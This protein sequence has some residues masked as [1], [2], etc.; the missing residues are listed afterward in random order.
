VIRV[1]DQ[2]HWL[3]AVT[4]RL[5]AELRSATSVDVET[6]ETLHSRL[7]QTPTTERAV[8]FQRELREKQQFEHGTSLVENASHLAAALGRLGLD[9][10]CVATGIERHRTR[11]GEPPVP[12]ASHRP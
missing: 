4:S 6:N 5:A 12:F 2:R 9:L 3:Y 11:F 8:S 7:F 10:G 1:N